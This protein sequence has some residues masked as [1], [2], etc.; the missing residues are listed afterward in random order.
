MRPQ[1]TPIFIG[2]EGSSEV[3][4]ASWLRNIVRDRD[5]PLHLEL[6]DLGRGAGDPLARIELARERIGRFESNRAAFAARFIFLDTDQLEGHRERAR[7]AHQLAREEGIVVLWQDPT[8]EAFLL[9][10]FPRCL[11]MMPPDK[12]AADTAL[13]RVWPD[14]QKPCNARQIEQCLSLEGAHRVASHHDDFAHFLRTIG[15]LDA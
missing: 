6:S 7:L 14:Y 13:R 15:L 10:H 3:G 2:C 12:R 11:T 9:R 8:H 5:L 1:R 4:Y